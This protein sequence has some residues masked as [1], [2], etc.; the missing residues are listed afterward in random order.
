MDDYLTGCRHQLQE[1]YQRYVNRFGPGLVIYWHGFLEIL[2]SKDQDV[3]VLDSFPSAKALTVLPQVP[4]DVD[5]A[6]AN[7]APAAPVSQL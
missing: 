7:C 5:Q 3:L 1:Q 4:L 2:N 6:S